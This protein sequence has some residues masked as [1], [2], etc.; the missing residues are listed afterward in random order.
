MQPDISLKLSADISFCNPKIHLPENIVLSCYIRGIISLPLN[1]FFATSKKTYILIIQKK[2]EDAGTGVLPAQASPVFTYLC[3]SIGE[4]LDA[5]RFDDPDNNDLQNA[6][7]LFKLF[8]ADKYD[9]GLMTASDM[10]DA[11]M[12]LL[13]INVFDKDSSWIIERQWSD[14]E[15][16]ALG[17]KEKQNTASLSEFC[18]MLNDL[19]NTISGIV[20]DLTIMGVS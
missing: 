17:I 10:S 5:N 20:S 19:Q 12:K 7:R 15:K 9:S 6:A 16:E 2:Q 1:S 14:E 11:R 8:K 18:D 4:T 13:D 3:S